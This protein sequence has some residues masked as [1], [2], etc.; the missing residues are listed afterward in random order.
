MFKLDN[1]TEYQIEVTTYCNAA[2]P[3]CPRNN[4]GHGV[5]PYLPLTHLDRAVIDRAFTKDVM[6]NVRQV[7]F[8]GGYG[9]P[10]M[11]PDFLGILSDFRKKNPRTWLYIHTNGG[12]HDPDYWQQIARTMAGYGQ[13]DFGIDG[14]EDTLHLYRRNVKYH[15]VIENATAFI[16][17]GGQAQ[18]NFIVFQH[19]QHQVEQ[20]KEISE[21]LGFEKILIR[22]TGRFF[23]HETIE[24]MSEWPVANQS[25]VLKVPS[26]DRYRNK[27]MRFLPDLK[28]EY[29]SI[30]KYFDTTPIQ[31]DALLGKK[32]A[33]SAPGLMLPCNFLNHH[34]YDARFYNNALPGAH[35]LS[36][37]ANGKN[38]VREFLE[39]YGLDNLNINHKSLAEIFDS[40]VWSDIVQGFDKKIGQGRLF[41]CAM[42]C[43]SKLTKVWD[44]GGSKR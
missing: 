21:R 7:F 9:D 39:S 33:I 24:E 8:C 5:N 16:N 28:K 23:N 2:C 17:A 4:L 11:H 38:Q 37:N 35:A 3:Q 25:Y 20:A 42:T 18:W 44:Q 29:S 40:P 26:D 22:N 19:N 36:N 13:I 43:G 10:I 6:S 41:E 32:V 30:N 34:L 31:C 27:S 15:K 14:L 12:V 1:I